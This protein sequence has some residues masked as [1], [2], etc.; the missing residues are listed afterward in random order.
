MFVFQQQVV[1]RSIKISISTS[2]L[3]FCA[4]SPH[5]QSF[6]TYILGIVETCFQRGDIFLSLIDV[7]GQRSE[8]KKWL[9]CFES[10][11]TILFIVS[12]SEYDQTL[13][14]DG[15]VNRMKESLRL[16]T[17]VCNVKWFSKASMILFLNKKDVFDEKIVYSP[18]TTCFETYYGPQQKE[19]ASAY[20]SQQFLSQNHSKREVYRHFTC[21]KNS[22]NI[23]VVFDSVADVISQNLLLDIGLI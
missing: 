14:E 1:S 9:H 7:G 16:F 23:S 22:E 19:E 21:A 10:V 3:H 6:H 11:N 4:V 2:F 5:I 17:S 8:R 18:I 20:I 13:E 15:Q 12:M